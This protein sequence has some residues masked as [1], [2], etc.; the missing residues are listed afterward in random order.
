MFPSRIGATKSPSVATS[1]VVGAFP[2]V[3]KLVRSSPAPSSNRPA[4]SRV[5]QN[6]IQSNLDNNRPRPSSAAPGKPAGVSNQAVE[7][8]AGGNGTQV[9]AKT[10]KESVPASTTT[11]GQQE[12]ETTQSEA[13][14][15]ECVDSPTMS[16]RKETVSQMPEDRDAQKEPVT[17]VAAP[18]T[19]TPSVTTKSGRAS[20]P[21]TP[22]M[23]TFAEAINVRPRPSRHIE[24]TV[25]VV[26]RSHKKGGS[27]AAAV[28]LAAQQTADTGEPRHN[29]PDEE[30]EAEIDG[31]EPRYC[32]C[33]GVSYGEMVAC[34][35]EACPR[36][37][38]HLE[39]VGL[40]VAPRGNG[41]FSAQAT[42]HRS[43]D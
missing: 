42:W 33:D 7:S 32:Y 5:R 17:S 38:F 43:W 21:S 6:S 1:P 22:A 34:D 2:E 11:S 12:A 4:S 24:S 20:K 8:E 28:A 9:D 16:K 19:A 23:A 35:A 25:P 14:Q 26:K 37:W 3:A 39:C 36:E 41:M 13:Q 10:H 29:A 15:P 27:I 30:D 40:K 31:D 18:A